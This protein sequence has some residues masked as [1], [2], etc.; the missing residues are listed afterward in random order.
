MG[1]SR[2]EVILRWYASKAVTQLVILWLMSIVPTRGIT[3][4]LMP[5]WN[6]DHIFDAIAP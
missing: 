4:P 5:E 1:R 2:S 3:R 6:D